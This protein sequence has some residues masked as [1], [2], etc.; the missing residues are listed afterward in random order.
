MVSCL[1]QC[2]PCDQGRAGSRWCKA[3]VCMWV[4]D[5]PCAKTK[6]RGR[7]QNKTGEYYC[8]GSIIIFPCWAMIMSNFKIIQQLCA[9]FTEKQYNIKRELLVSNTVA[10]RCLLHELLNNDFP[11]TADKFVIES[12]KKKSCFRFWMSPIT[13]DLPRMY[14]E[15]TTCQLRKW[16]SGVPSCWRPQHYKWTVL[17]SRNKSKVS[18]AFR[19]FI[20]P[21]WQCQQRKGFRGRRLEWKSH[22]G[23]LV[24]DLWG[25]FCACH[26]G[27]GGRVFGLSVWIKL[28]HQ[29]CLPFL[30]HLEIYR[31]RPPGPIHWEIQPVV[32][33]AGGVLN[34]PL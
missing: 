34:R 25:C 16:N 24:F 7:K 17:L 14:S 21:S 9:Y 26:G 20:K 6:L 28:K 30:L 2:F 4:H 23:W 10:N 31:R 29:Q 27:Q 18:M 5:I 33:V 13:S 3:E 8:L 12:K 32:A 11:Q 22:L 19:T 1:F 15:S